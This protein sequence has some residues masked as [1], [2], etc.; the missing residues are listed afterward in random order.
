V[1]ALGSL[2]RRPTETR[3]M[4]GAARLRPPLRSRLSCVRSVFH[5]DFTRPAKYKVDTGCNRHQ[6]GEEEA[7]GTVTFARPTNGDGIHSPVPQS[8]TLRVRPR[9]CPA[10]HIKRAWTRRVFRRHPQ[11]VLLRLAQPRSVTGGALSSTTSLSSERC[12]VA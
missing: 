6:Q 4:V 7:Y 2:Q 3:R 12:P 11:R 10:S 9:A 1:D 5:G 8:K